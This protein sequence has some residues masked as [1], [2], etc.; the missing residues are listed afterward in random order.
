MAVDPS[1][2]GTTEDYQLARAADMLRGVSL[3]THRTPE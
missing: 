1:V 2:M 3:F